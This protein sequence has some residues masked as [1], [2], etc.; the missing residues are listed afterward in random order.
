MT[1]GFDK[2][3]KKEQQEL[4]KLIKEITDEAKQVVDDY[5]QNPSEISGSII[6][7]HEDSPLLEEE[8]DSQTTSYEDAPTKDRKRWGG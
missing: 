2:L 8:E 6:Q 1:R 3:T 5:T 4:E 7:I